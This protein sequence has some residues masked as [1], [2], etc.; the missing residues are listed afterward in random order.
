MRS[1]RARL[2]LVV[3]LG[4][5]LAGCRLELEV[6]VDVGDDGAGAV[7]V[8]VG[9]DPDGI[10][11]IGGDLGSVLVL[12][13]LTEAGW[14]VEEPTVD[15]DGYTRL[16]IRRPFADSAEAADVFRE[17]AAD[18][19]PFQDFA[20]SR[21]SSFART[22]WTFDGRVD[23]SGGLEAFGDEGLAAELDGEPLGQ[24]VEEIEAQLGESLDRVIRVRVG[25]RL[26][27]DVSSNA[28]TEAGHG[29]VWEVAFG[30]GP[31]PLRATSE[32][33]RMATVV[34]VGVAGACVVALLLYGLVRL[35]RRTSRSQADR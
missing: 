16:R 9:L 10:E 1:R 19:G 32:E 5:V 8:V 22:R 15:A 28:T 33:T 14:V 24:S 12:D 4:L 2:S 21:T 6:N 23:F 31:V 27:R 26:P 35:T 18:S 20:V 25:V 30:D 11:R 29:A 34:G 3:L 13:G 17:V 7:E